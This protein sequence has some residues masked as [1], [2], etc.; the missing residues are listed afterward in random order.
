MTFDMIDFFLFLNAPTLICFFIMA[1][2]AGYFLI[3]NGKALWHSIP[4]L[5]NEIWG[6]K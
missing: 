1:C 2:F 4:F 3:V 5:W 6:K